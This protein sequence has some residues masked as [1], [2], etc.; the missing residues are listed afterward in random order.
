M[1]GVRGAGLSTVKI[2]IPEG[3][4]A[5]VKV[6]ADLTPV[7]VNERR[8]PRKGDFYVSSDFDTA[9]NRVELE[10]DADLSTIEV[11]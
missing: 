4:A 1:G 7:K 10:I 2:M 6:Q 9:K 3:V 5:R 8:F 11:K